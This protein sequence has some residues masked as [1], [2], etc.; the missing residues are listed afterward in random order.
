MKNN[1][2]NCISITSDAS[3]DVKPINQNKWSTCKFFPYQSDIKQYT[4][5]VSLRYQQNSKQ[6][7]K[8]KTLKSNWTNTQRLSFMA[9]LLWQ[10]DGIH[11]SSRICWKSTSHCSCRHTNVALLNSAILSLLNGIRICFLLHG[12]Y[13]LNLPG[14]CLES[15]QGPDLHRNTIHGI[16]VRQDIAFAGSCGLAAGE[17]SNKIQIIFVYNGNRTQD[18][19]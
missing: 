17:W 2:F 15:V 7:L 9:G 12:L 3:L 19:T 11:M 8:T 6:K 1:H 13:S 4:H 10:N 5:D 18:T 16:P 14:I